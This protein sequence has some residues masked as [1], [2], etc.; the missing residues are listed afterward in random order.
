MLVLSRLLSLEAVTIYFDSSGSIARSL[1]F[2]LTFTTGPL[3]DLLPD[4]ID[5]CDDGFFET[6]FLGV[7]EALRS[8]FSFALDACISIN[9]MLLI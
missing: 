3:F 8:V 1:S 7:P 4:Y 6:I 5:I 2:L 9:P